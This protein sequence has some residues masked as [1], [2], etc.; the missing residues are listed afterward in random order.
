[1]LK[2]DYSEKCVTKIVPTVKHILGLD[3]EESLIE[4]RS[5]KVLLV[6]ID[7]LGYDKLMELIDEDENLKETI[8]MFN[9]E[10]ITTSF[11]TSTVPGLFSILSGKPPGKHGLLEW[12]SYNNEL[13]VRYKPLPFEAVEDE[14]K[15][16]FGE[17][18]MKE[19]IWPETIQ[20]MLSGEMETYQIQPKK[21]IDDEEKYR[22]G[23]GNLVEAFVKT[24]K[25]VKKEDKKSFYYLY[26][27]AL[28]TSNH[29]N[30]PD[31]EESEELVKE[32][33]R[34]MEKYIL[35]ELD[36]LHVIVT[37]DHGFMDIQDK[38]DMKE[39]GELY[40]KISPY[41]ETHQDKEIKPVGAPRMVNFHVEN[42]KV[43]EFIDI[44]NDEIDADFNLIK[45]EKLLEDGFFSEG[46]L[47]EKFVESLG[48]VTLIM[49]GN[50]IITFEPY[51]DYEG[52]HGGLTEAELYVPFL[53]KRL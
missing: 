25:A 16:K 13:G 48:N 24:S 43:E 21:I 34:L 15:E 23:Y 51:D 49:T 44:L 22:K 27:S 33:F 6:V 35:K 14:D 47:S 18:V 8:K 19:D 11:P 53:S 10:K 41:L 29:E 31:E 37:A 2:P 42:D 36:D 39:E 38:V 17:T 4:E 32:I 9:E 1:M 40:K 12:V 20:D 5:D 46:E 28:D 50:S 45:T 3:S 26:I 7:G 52:M 30:G